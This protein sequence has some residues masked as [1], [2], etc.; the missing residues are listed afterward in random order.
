MKL[1][2]AAQKGEIWGEHK[3]YGITS[4]GEKKKSPNTKTNLKNKKGLA[5]YLHTNFSVIVTD[6]KVINSERLKWS[7]LDL[8]RQKELSFVGL[9]RSPSNTIKKGLKK[10]FGT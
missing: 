5:T 7:K 8:K 1:S 3:A 2:Q 10:S 4:T 9:K 6:D